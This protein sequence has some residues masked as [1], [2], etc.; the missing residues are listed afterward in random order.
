MYS[1]PNKYVPALDK[2][3]I[4]Q[5]DGKTLTKVFS[6]EDA[7][8][9]IGKEIEFKACVH[10]IRSMSG[11]S[12]VVLRTSRYLVQTIYNPQDCKDSIDGIKEGCFVDVKGIVTS[13]EK[14]YHGI[15]IKLTSIS[16]ISKPAYEYPL[17]VSDK[18]LGCAL[19]INLDNRSVALRNAQ[20]RAIFK[21]Q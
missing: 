13:N 6:L 16:M 18:K 1:N 20:Q 19:D 11:F 7:L 3:K 10:K 4:L 21:L 2:D 12:F 14:G 15:E 9:N 5:V 8:N 17:R